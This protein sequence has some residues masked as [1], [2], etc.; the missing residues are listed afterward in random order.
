MAPDGSDVLSGWMR[1]SMALGQRNAS[2]HLSFCPQF[3]RAPRVTVKQLEGPR[4]RIKTVQVLPHGARFDLKLAAP[5][6]GPETVLLRFSAETG[7]PTTDADATP[8]S[9]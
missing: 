2:V 6:E 5:S 4:A 7:R 1:V 8:T 9:P 3:S